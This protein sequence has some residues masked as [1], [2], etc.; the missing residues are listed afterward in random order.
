MF[1]IIYVSQYV[2]Y[3]IENKI[4]SYLSYVF[5]TFFFTT[6][7]TQIKLQKC[8]RLESRG[9]SLNIAVINFSARKKKQFE[10][11]KHFLYYEK[12]FENS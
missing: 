12:H 9:C 4:I 2:L 10:I 11:D 3:L 6:S 1:Y 5:S 8:A 7:S